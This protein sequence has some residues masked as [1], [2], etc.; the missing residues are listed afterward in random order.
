[1]APRKPSPVSNCPHWPYR[2]FSSSDSV[3]RPKARHVFGGAA[4]SG[5][6]EH[7]RLRCC[8]LPCSL[9]Q[10]SATVGRNARSLPL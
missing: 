2:C 6:L 4:G 3:L 1:V 7:T 10:K 9:R 8:P 5:S